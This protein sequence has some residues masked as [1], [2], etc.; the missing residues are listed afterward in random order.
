MADPISFKEEASKLIERLATEIEGFFLL[1][2]FLFALDSF[3]YRFDDR[4]LTILSFDWSL[5]HGVNVG[6]I[7]LFLALFSFI[8]TVVVPLLL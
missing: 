1:S 8:M 6:G 4:H 2:S 5:A 7:L 3:L